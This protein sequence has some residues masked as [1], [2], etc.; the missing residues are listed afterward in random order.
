MKPTLNADRKATKKFEAEN[1]D[2]WLYSL[3]I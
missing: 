3:S 1:F 2:F